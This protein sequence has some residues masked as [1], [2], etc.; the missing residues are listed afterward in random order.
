MDIDEAETEDDSTSQDHDVPSTDSPCD[1]KNISDGFSSE[2]SD[3]KSNRET[4]RNIN[5][6]PSVAKLRTQ[7][8]ETAGLLRD[9]TYHVDNID[10]LKKAMEALKKIHQSLMCNTL[11][12]KRSSYTQQ[13]SKEAL[14]GNK[15]GLSKYSTRNY[16]CVEKEKYV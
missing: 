4:N 15:L 10:C 16:L 14:K 13:S 8:H 2:R 9:A 6:D 11:S 3:C 7:V 1:Y 5:S 12:R